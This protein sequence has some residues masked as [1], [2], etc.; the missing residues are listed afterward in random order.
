MADLMPAL[1]SPWTELDAGEFLF[2]LLVIKMCYLLGIEE[3]EALSNNNLAGLGFSEEKPDWYGGKVDFRGKLRDHSSANITEYKIVLERP[4]LGTSCR[5]TRRLGS[6]SI[7][8]ISIPPDVFTKQDNQLVDFFS[9]PFILSGRVFRAFY[10]KGKHVFLLKT[11][12]VF[13]GFKIS[14]P[15]DAAH[16]DGLTLLDFLNWHN[17]LESNKRQAS[18]F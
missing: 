8:R 3:I 16:G 2:Q 13:D 11:C 6:Q 12:E 18:I 17:P 14:V 10:A 1:Q 5:F 7:L 4:E 9:R 15:K